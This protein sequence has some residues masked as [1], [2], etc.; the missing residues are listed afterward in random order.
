MLAPMC[1]DD[2]G[3]FKGSFLDE[4]PD[5]KHFALEIMTPL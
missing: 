1:L 2:D 4:K 5:Q 3:S